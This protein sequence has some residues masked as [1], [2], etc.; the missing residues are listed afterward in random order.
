MH[1]LLFSLLLV[2]LPTQLGY[3]VWP[4]WALVLGRRIDYISP[5]LYATDILI[6]LLLVSWCIEKKI[7][8][9]Y[10]KKIRRSARN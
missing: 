2:F 3:H 9:F 5:T 8:I 7:N 4:D 1:M 6:V 10:F